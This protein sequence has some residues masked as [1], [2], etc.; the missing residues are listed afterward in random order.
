MD[1]FALHTCQKSKLRIFSACDVCEYTFRGE[2]YSESAPSQ[3]V[4]KLADAHFSG[5][6]L[7]TV[8]QDEDM[9]MTEL[10]VKGLVCK[11]SAGQWSL[12]DV[13]AG[14]IQA[15]T[16]LNNPALVLRVREGVEPLGMTTW[17]LLT[18]MQAQGWLLHKLHGKARPPA[19]TAASAG[20]GD[21]IV[22][23]FYVRAAK[24]MT[25]ARYYLCALLV[26]AEPVKH[27]E[28]EDYYKQLLGIPT[29]QHSRAPRDACSDDEMKAEGSLHARQPMPLRIRAPR[30]KRAGKKKKAKVKAA[31]IRASSSESSSSSRESSSSSSESSSSGICG[32]DGAGAVGEGEGVVAGEVGGA[33]EDGPPAL[34]APAGR[35][36]RGAGGFAYGPFWFTAGKDRWQARCCRKH[37][38]RPL[39]PLAP[40]SLCRKTLTYHTEDQERIV[41]QRLK[42]W[43][44]QAWAPACGTRAEHI[45][46]DGWGFPADPDEEKPPTDYESDVG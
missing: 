21:A 11:L 17:E 46:F 2:D 6:H 23:L 28:Q 14:R 4:T 43:C 1:H 37:S 8:S 41:L 33:G 19:Y 16:R 40:N 15:C 42:H 44:N 26:V 9:E 18:T 12:S 20:S 7:N 39:P 32:L 35:V 3:L 24:C 13:G 22:K 34:A 30:V 45:G 27:L 29:K 31:A 10:L 38:H 25:I 36:A 5:V